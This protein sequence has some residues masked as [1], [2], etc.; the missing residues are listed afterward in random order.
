MT[1]KLGITFADEAKDFEFYVKNLAREAAEE[2]NGP[3]LW[4]SPEKAV[5]TRPKLLIEV[6]ATFACV[7]T[8]AISFACN[9]G[10][11]RRLHAG[12]AISVEKHCTKTTTVSS[13]DIHA[14]PQAVIPSF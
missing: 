12:N 8:S 5:P 6:F 4:N 14:H 9:K 3:G 10:N 2:Q 1:C 7:Q 11:R 13:G